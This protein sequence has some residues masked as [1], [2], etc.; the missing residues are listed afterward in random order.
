VQSGTIG[1]TVEPRAQLVAG[2]YAAGGQEVGDGVS[3]RY[4]PSVIEPHGDGEV[5]RGEAILEPTN[6]FRVWPVR[7]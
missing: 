1:L 5:F 3:R 7:L 2:V 6:R 4:L